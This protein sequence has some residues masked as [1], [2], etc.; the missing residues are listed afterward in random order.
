MKFTHRIEET[1]HPETFRSPYIH[2]RLKFRLKSHEQTD[3]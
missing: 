1:G 2:V 3:I